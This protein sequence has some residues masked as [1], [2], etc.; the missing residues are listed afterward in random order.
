MTDGATGQPNTGPGPQE[1]APPVRSDDAIL[2]GDG[3][4]LPLRAWLPSDRDTIRAALLAV[5]GFNDYSGAFETLGTRL[6]ERGIAVYAYDQRGFG[7]TSRPG[8]WHAHETLVADLGTAVTAIRARH[9]ASPCHLLGESM[10]AAV[11]L[12]ALTHPTAACRPDVER[13][14]LV[15]T[16]VWGG[17]AL[18]PIARAGLLAFGALLPRVRMTKPYAPARMPSDNQAMLE[19]LWRD[20]LAITATRISAVAGLVRLVDAAMAAAPR[21]DVPAL[22][23]FGDQDRVN[24]PKAVQIFLKLLPQGRQRIL[25]YPNGWHMLLR[26]IQADMVIADIAKWLDDPTTAELTGRDVSHPD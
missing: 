24:P 5:H 4:H 3:E 17:K 12:L 15:S 22:V 1:S 21:F 2:T 13:V 20:P 16:A 25:F 9:P 6:A 23:Q 11:A 19:A 14:V 18:N 8:V 7:A 26:D 10:G